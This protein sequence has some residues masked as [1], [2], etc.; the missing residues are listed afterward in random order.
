M[1]KAA[2]AVLA[3]ARAF[4]GKRLTQKQYEELLSCKSTNEIAS[5][6]RT[7]T[8]YQNVIDSSGFTDFSEKV[9]EDLVM[10]HNFEK[11]ASFC[12]FELAIG[13][14]FYK[15]FIIKTEID[16]ILNCTLRM[17]GGNRDG[18]LHEMNT[19]LDKHLGIDLFALGKANSLEEIALS[20]DKTQYGKIYRSCLSVENV[21]YLNFETAF[22]NYFESRTKQLVLKCFSGKE[23]KE[24]IEI[25]SRSLDCR[26]VDKISRILRY[27][28][29]LSLSPT[30]VT[31]SV[32]LSLFNEKQLKRLASCKNFD[33]FKTE[34][35][36]SP[37]KN[38]INFDA[39]ADIERQMKVSLIA[40]CAKRI[41]FSS[42]PSVVMFCYIILSQNEVS[43]L[44]RIIEGKKYEISVQEIKNNLIGIAD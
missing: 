23:E 26:L 38:V 28:S 4:Y 29:S 5:Y 3:L 25:I 39:D 40:Y 21:N 34:I 27:Y 41:R 15:Y 2:N 24:L 44:V 30:S 36:N 10:K 18:Y 8:D 6:L 31:K 16:E 11:L 33:A 19:F 1:S 13:S 35:L 7:R 14:D 22:S 9:L 42:Y 20:L 43:N 12:R 32:A 17:L 37:Y